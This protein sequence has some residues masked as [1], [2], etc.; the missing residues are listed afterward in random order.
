[1]KF[2]SNFSKLALV[3]VLLLKGTKHINKNKKIK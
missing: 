1:M 3:V 2:L